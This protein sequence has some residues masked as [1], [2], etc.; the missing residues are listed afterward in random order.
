MPDIEEINSFEQRQTF[1]YEVKSYEIQLS[2]KFDGVYKVKFSVA[3]APY[4]ASQQ[5]E[6][7]ERVSKRLLVGK[8]AIYKGKPVFVKNISSDRRIT[9]INTISKQAQTIQL[10]DN[11]FKLLEKSG[12]NVFSVD[13]VPEFFKAQKH[14]WRLKI[15]TSEKRLLNV[16]HEKIRFRQY[17]VANKRQDTYIPDGFETLFGNMRIQLEEIKG[18][19]LPQEQNRKQQNLKSAIDPR[20]EI[21]LM[22][23]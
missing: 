8:F 11:D 16:I 15:I 18:L 5:N 17:H 3:N 23:F 10:P 1:K 9:V 2:D 14:A 4:N 20:I 22:D 7:P 13:K 19:I 6:C 12:V 21:N